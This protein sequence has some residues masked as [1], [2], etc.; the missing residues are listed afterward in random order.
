MNQFFGAYPIIIAISSLLGPSNL[1]EHW[2]SAEYFICIFE[3]G[4]VPSEDGPEGREKRQ[5][6]KAAI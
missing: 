3:H 2:V 6:N 1:V 4:L 5:Q